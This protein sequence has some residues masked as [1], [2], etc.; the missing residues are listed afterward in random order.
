MDETL[1]IV[2]EGSVTEK[3]QGGDTH[4]TPDNVSDETTF[5]IGPL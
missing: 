1:E 5:K 4:V 2:E 3:T